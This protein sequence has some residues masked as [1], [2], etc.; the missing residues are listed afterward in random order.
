MVA[1][2]YDP[3]VVAATSIGGI[4]YQ[5]IRQGV[6]SALRVVWRTRSSPADRWFVCGELVPERNAFA[7][8]GWDG[9]L[10]GRAS[11]VR[12]GLAVVGHFY[13]SAAM[14]TA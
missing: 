1:G 6:S 7:V 14:G 10:I 11:S 3:E 12:D 5:A 13:I 8:H 9:Q 2:T 4:E